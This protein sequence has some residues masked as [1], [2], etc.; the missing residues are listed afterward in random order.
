MPRYR[1]IHQYS[2]ETWEVEASSSEDARKIVGWSPDICHAI[3][4]RHGSS[5]AILPPKVAVQITPPKSGSIH[6][7]PS[8]N[9]TMIEKLNN[10]FWWQCPSCDQLYHEMDNEF[11]G[12]DEFLVD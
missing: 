6:I 9:V 11:Y 4:L 12:R 7:C 3:K 2:K 10:D 5:T 1:V 8:C